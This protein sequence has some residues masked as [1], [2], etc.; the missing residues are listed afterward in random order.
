MKYDE[1]NKEIDSLLELLNDGVELSDSDLKTI[2][3]LMS[4]VEKVKA[5]EADNAK[6]KVEILWYEHI[7]KTAA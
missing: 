7:N 3:S 1:I 4:D 5:K 6:T 2:D